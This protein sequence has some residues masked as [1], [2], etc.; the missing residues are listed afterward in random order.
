M[1]LIAFAH[2]RGTPII[3]SGGAGGKVDCTCIRHGD[4]ARVVGDPLIGAV[5]QRLRKEYGFAR[6]AVK[7]QES[8][9][10]GIEAVYSDE[11][12]KP[13]QDG[14]DGFGVFVGVT[15]TFG[16]LLA[17]RAVLQVLSK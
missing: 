10:F 3:V 16:M 6:G 9:R 8:K 7:V 2:E 17:Q 14:G 11:P 15:A 13:S 4:L 1:A 12:V 5:R